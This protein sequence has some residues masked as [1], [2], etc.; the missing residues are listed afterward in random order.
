VEPRT[1]ADSVAVDLIFNYSLKQIGNGSV[2][3]IALDQTQDF[4]RP[5]A[6]NYFTQVRPSIQD[7]QG[8]ATWRDGD[9]SATVVGI[10]N[11]LN[12]GDLIMES[13]DGTPA[14]KPFKII[15]DV[16]WVDAD[17]VPRD[18]WDSCVPPD[19]GGK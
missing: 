19:L 15:V 18:T 16:D 13:L 5:S 17:G 14:V 7:L 1:A 2:Q 9:L 8:D 4:S 11:S 3:A 6:Y 10:K 12:L